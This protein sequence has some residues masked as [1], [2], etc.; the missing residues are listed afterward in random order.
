MSEVKCPPGYCPLQN[1]KGEQI[2][3]VC[4]KCGRLFG[5]DHLPSC[6]RAMEAR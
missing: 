6:S 1:F 4:V 2:G 3:C 5:K